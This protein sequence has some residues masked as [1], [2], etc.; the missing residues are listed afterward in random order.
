MAFSARPS[1]LYVV[2]HH[3]EDI[4]K[5]IEPHLDQV[6]KACYSR[7]IISAQAYTQVMNCDR[8]RKP[9]QLLLA[10]K[11]SVARTESN[12]DAFL[13]VL[14]DAVPEKSLKNLLGKLNATL[15]VRPSNDG[16]HKAFSVPTKLQSKDIADPSARETHE[17]EPDVGDDGGL[18][19]RRVPRS[20]DD[21]ELEEEVKKLTKPIQETQH[22]DIDE[23]DK[24]FEGLVEPIEESRD[25]ENCPSVLKQRKSADMQKGKQHVNV[26]LDKVL[27]GDRTGVRTVL[28]WWQQARLECQ[29][30]EAVVQNLL[31]EIKKLRDQLSCAHEEENN[32]TIENQKL[33]EYIETLR[34]QQKEE[35][36]ALCTAKQAEGNERL[37]EQIS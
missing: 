23:H 20:S 24:S 25:D 36:S 5:V 4:L 1:K 26:H 21:E 35:V 32:L 31:E 27:E 9:N 33:S 3:S 14:K 29:Q 16:V 12:Y 19:F 30:Q 8:T 28:N 34:H 22:P 17:A 10:I 15:Q 11:N 2:R 18:Q 7:I 6:L 37:R 13:R